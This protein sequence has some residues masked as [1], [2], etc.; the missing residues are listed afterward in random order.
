MLHAQSHPTLVL[1]EARAVTLA[2]QNNLA[3][4]A[5][6]LE[7]LAADLRVADARSAWTPTAFSRLAHG[8]ATLPSTSILTGAGAS[9]DS[10]SFQAGFAQRL[11]WGSHYQVAW[12]SGTRSSS[13]LLARYNP[14][15]TSRLNLTV[16]Q[17][18][19]HAVGIDRDRAAAAQATIKRR[20]AD[21]DVDAAVAATVRIARVAFWQWS[22][23]LDVQQVQQR[24]LELARQLLR[25]NQRRVAS[26]ALAAADVIEAEAEVA[27]REESVLVAGSAV[28]TAEDRLRRILFDP[29]Q[30]APATL[31]RDAAAP[32]LAVD[33]ASVL[34]RALDRRIELHQLR[35]SIESDSVSIRLADVEARP[36]VTLEVNYVSQSLGGTELLR[37]GGFPGAV[38]G[39][40]QRTFGAALQDVW[41]GAYPAWST[42]VAVQYPLGTS[43]ADAARAAAR[44]QQRRA[45]LRLADAEVEVRTEVAA[46]VREAETN[47]QRID[48]TRTAVA[49]AERRLEAEQRKFNAGLSSS[50]LVF[51]AQ[52]DLATAREAELRAARDYRVSVADVD[53]VQHV[54]LTPGRASDARTAP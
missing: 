13:N 36:D 23:A 11:P 7:T 8:S 30:A 48:T 52:R 25:D 44:L 14:E 31:Q 2:L 19:I 26:G 33:A 9:D 49:L 21:A 37:S 35:R 51:Q 10:T 5:E 18:L 50:F 20:Q 1:D 45:E 12:E 3:L 38:I 42:Q 22:H 53:A 41:S 6:R 4:E 29:R 34:A 32:P 47:R 17:S 24:S 43:R 46:A 40:T 27:R 15:V 16:T 54:P 28:A 39:T